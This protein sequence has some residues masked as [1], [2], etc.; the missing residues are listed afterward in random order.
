MKIPDE[1]INAPVLSESDVFYVQSFYELDSERSF[2][3]VP[4]PI[5]RSKIVEYG[6]EVG[7]S[8][9]DLEDFIYLVRAIDIGHMDSI[10][11]KQLQKGEN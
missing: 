1:I 2:G 5:P 8:G 3:E 4:G 11:K 10:N 7:L 9:D 6:K